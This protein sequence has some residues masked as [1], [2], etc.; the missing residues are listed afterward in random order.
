MAEFWGWTG[1]RMRLTA[2]G[3]RL[4]RFGE[5]LIARQANF[6]EAKDILAAIGWGRVDGVILDLG[7]S[8]H[9]FDA[10]ERGFS[11]RGASISTCAWTGASG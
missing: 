8:S 6:A 9:Q 10:P 5:R 7:V 2:A 3:Q 4:S 11:F 1:M